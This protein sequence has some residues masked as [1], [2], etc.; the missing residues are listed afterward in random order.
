MDALNPG[1]AWAR[2]R[3]NSHGSGA[4]FDRKKQP[5]LAPEMRV[6]AERQDLCIVSFV[7]NDGQVCG[8]LLHGR[9][10]EFAKAPDDHH[11]IIQ[12]LNRTMGDL[13]SSETCARSWQLAPINH[14]FQ[15]KT[16]ICTV[17]L[18]RAFILDPISCELC[19]FW[20]FF[21]NQFDF[22]AG[23]ANLFA[24]QRESSC[25]LPR[26]REATL[27]LVSWVRILSGTAQ[28]TESLV[29]QAKKGFER[30]GRAEFNVNTSDARFEPSG[31]LKES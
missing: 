21:P 28:D 18:I 22:C 26:S 11:L 3:W 24:S 9:L 19:W 14:K 17:I 16:C 4:A 23:G 15:I 12:P 8:R 27:S 6:F 31:N 7:D 2:T 1:Q 10:G 25:P 20:S 13:P 29:N 30:I 5:Y